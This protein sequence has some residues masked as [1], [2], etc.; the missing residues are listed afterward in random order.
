M[1]T[2]AV[3]VNM[4][5]TP[6]EYNIA[7]AKELIDRGFD[8]IQFDY[9]RFPTDGYNLTDTSYRWQ[10]EGMDM[11]SALISFLS[12]ARQN[13]QAPIGIDIYGVNGWYRSGTRTGQDVELMA[14]YVDVISPMFYPSHFE[15]YFLAY[16]PITERPYRVYFYGTYRNAVIARNRVLIRPWLQAFY[17]NPASYDREFYNDD[18]VQRQVFGVRDATDTGY[19]YWNNSGRYSDLRPDVGDIEEATPYPWEKAKRDASER[20]PALSGD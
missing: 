5:T 10:D 4:A 13:I 3:K 1:V 14:P 2:K 18:Y 20:L 7:I 12:Y 19:M 9:I 17:Y 8:E 15:Q 6:W 11:E 16:T